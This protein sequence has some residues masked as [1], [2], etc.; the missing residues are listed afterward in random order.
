MCIYT[1]PI[2]FPICMHRGAEE[3][4]ESFRLGLQNLLSEFQGLPTMNDRPGTVNRHHEELDQET[5]QMPEN[6]HNPLRDAG[7]D[8]PDDEMLELTPVGPEAPLA[9]GRCPGQIS[10]DID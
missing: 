10:G 5:P 4:W 2:L 8:T 3:E 1:S 7:S 9:A 6:N